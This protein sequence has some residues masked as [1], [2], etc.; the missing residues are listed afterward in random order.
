M[1]GGGSCNQRES[2]A[3]DHAA[4]DEIEQQVYEHSMKCGRGGKAIVKENVECSEKWN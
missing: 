1:V 4:T 2:R 3:S